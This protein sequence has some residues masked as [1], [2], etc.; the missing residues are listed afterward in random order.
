MWIYLT[1]DI[2]KWV[3]WQ[4]VVVWVYLFIYLPYTQ[5]SKLRNHSIQML[6]VACYINLEY[7]NANN[8][9]LIFFLKHSNLWLSLTATLFLCIGN[10]SWKISSTYLG[11]VFRVKMKNSSQLA[12][13][14]SSGRLPPN[15]YQL[16]NSKLCV[17]QLQLSPSLLEV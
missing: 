10:W 3:G 4:M 6:I 13:F 12:S 14:K 17:C 8:L 1:L 9:S 5:M 11:K 15:Q 16:W 7:P 2:S